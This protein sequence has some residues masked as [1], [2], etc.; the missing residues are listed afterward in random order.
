ME[1]RVG[2]WVLDKH[3]NVGRITQPRIDKDGTVVRWYHLEP[4]QMRSP[5]VKQKYLTVITEPVARII[6]N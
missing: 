1:L 5:Y 3:G 4:N 6:I 2:V